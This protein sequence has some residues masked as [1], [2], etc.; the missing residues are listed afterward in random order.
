MIEWLVHID[1][2]LMLFL[3]GFH[4]P[5]FDWIM[6]WSSD[7]RLWIP[8]YLFL[9][10][11]YIRKFKSFFLWPVVFTILAVALSDI[12]S[13]HLIKELIQRP[14]PTY[15]PEIAPLLHT[16]NGYTGGLYGFVYSHAANS[17][18]LSTLTL[19]FLR[20]RVLSFFM[21]LWAVLVSYSRIYL[22]VHY[23]GDVICGAMFGTILAL[24]LYYLWLK[25]PFFHPI[26]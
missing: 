20:N 12:I 24:I 23:P 22:G 3:N 25:I 13:V 7:R 15:D 4:S 21:F 10:I 14:R 17:F 5:F 18:A 16:L 8:L 19:L 11:L 1:R 2:E 6:W 26:S 9:L